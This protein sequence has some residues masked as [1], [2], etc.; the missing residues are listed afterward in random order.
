MCYPFFIIHQSYHLKWIYMCNFFINI[1]IHKRS[2][3]CRKAVELLCRWRNNSGAACLAGSRT[4]SASNGRSVQ[5]H[6]DIK[7]KFRSSPSIVVSLYAITVR[8][9]FCYIPGLL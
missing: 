7:D 2:L 1:K 3:I 8:G 9:L 4:S 6:K 5:K